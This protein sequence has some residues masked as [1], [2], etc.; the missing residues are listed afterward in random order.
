MPDES[1]DK[2]DVS[3]VEVRGKKRVGFDGLEH[4]KVDEQVKDELL[5]R[6]EYL[7]LALD[8]VADEHPAG[9]DRAWHIGRILDEHN[10]SESSDITIADIARYNSIGVDKRRMSYCR[11]IY[12]F[13]PNRG[14]DPSHSVT[15]LGELASRSR[16]QDREA[17]AKRGY[18]RL[19]EAGKELTRRDIFAW[20]GIN[21]TKTTLD[22]VVAEVID[23]YEE[24]K[25]IIESIKR[26]LLLTGQDPTDYTAEEIQETVKRHR[27]IKEETND[28]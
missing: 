23:Q 3:V 8:D 18:D 7:I 22:T 17:E 16:G 25:N 21:D 1:T 12:H 10:V 27:Q 24:P 2:I 11:N 6:Y 4:L 20:W 28:Q 19:V 5:E 15:A 9:P 13:F 26:I 14:Y